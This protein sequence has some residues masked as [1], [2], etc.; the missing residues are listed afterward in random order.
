MLYFASKQPIKAKNT[1]KAKV[2]ILFLIALCMIFIIPLN[3]LAEPL[4]LVTWEIPGGWVKD[5]DSGMKIEIAKE[6][7][8]RTGIQFEIKLYPPKRSI[9]VFKDNEVIGMFPALDVN[10]PKEVAKSE[11]YYSKKIYALIKKEKPDISGLEDMKGMKVGLVLGY[12]YPQSVTKNEN[13]I[14]DYA[15]GVENNVKKLIEGRFDVFL[16]EKTTL[17][18]I[19]K[20]MELQ[21][22]LEISEKPI[23]DMSAYFAFQP[24]EKGKE[25][26]D[27][28]S[29]AIREMRAD[30]TLE[31]IL[32][33]AVK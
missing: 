10:I 27:V 31:R 30:G 5:K 14:I 26:S 33:K 29:K 13:L 24:T 23:S 3:A 1:M 20:E 6:I 4:I 32:F 16:E 28:F 19:I 7:K 8:T 12:S 2:K 9:Q 18:K 17:F 25:L 15:S 11:P 21:N 22:V